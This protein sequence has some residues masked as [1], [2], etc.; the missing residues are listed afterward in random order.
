M[1]WQFYPFYKNYFSMYP[2]A[3][4]NVLLLPLL[5]G[6]REP[7]PSRHC[8][9]CECHHHAPPFA[10]KATPSRHSGGYPFFL[11]FSGEKTLTAAF[12]LRFPANHLPFGENEATTVFPMESSTKAL[13]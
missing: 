3:E 1:K 5:H 6:S 12:S 13:T 2:H 9:H 10:S 4:F 8:R 7:P 11:G